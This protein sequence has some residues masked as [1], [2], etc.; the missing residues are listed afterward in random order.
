MVFNT[1]YRN[2]HDIYMINKAVGPAFSFWKRLKMG[3]IGSKRMNIRAFSEALEKCKSQSQDK[4]FGF[5]EIRPKGVL[6]LINKQLQNFTWPISYQDLRIEGDT[7]LYI[8]T[9]KD[10]IHFE[11]GM[12]E[13]QSFIQQLLDRQK[14][15]CA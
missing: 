5:I 8:G 11:N 1:T 10:Y 12:A 14:R 2:D 3:G 15:F 6:I 13:N 4:Q 7:D 9:A